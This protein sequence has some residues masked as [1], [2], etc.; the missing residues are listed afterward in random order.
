MLSSLPRRNNSPLAKCGCK[1]HVLDLYGDHTSTCTAHSG[2]TKAHDW[3]VGVLG[4]LFRTAGHTVRT[5]HGVTASAGQRR[6]DVDLRSYPQDAAGRRSG[7]GPRQTCSSDVLWLSSADALWPP[8]VSPSGA[9]STQLEVSGDMRSRS[10]PCTN[11]SQDRAWVDMRESHDECG[12]GVPKQHHNKALCV[13]RPTPGLLPSWAPLPALLNRS[14]CRARPL[15]L[16]KTMGLLTAT[17]HARAKLIGATKAHDWMVSAL[18]PLF[19]TAGHTVRTQHGVPASA[20][21]RRGDVEIRHCLR[22]Q[23][24]SRSTSVNKHLS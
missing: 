17:T 20:G 22:D 10:R 16:Q 14:G 23:A 2:A 7:P 6:G 15:R 21:Q 24:G 1:K 12:F 8:S 5:Q 4:P 3:M 13:V 11:Q 9:P 19:R 18:G